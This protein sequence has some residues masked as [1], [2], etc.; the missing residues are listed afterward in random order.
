[1]VCH[2]CEEWQACEVHPVLACCPDYS[3]QF[4]LHHAVSRFGVCHE[5][6]A[7]LDQLPLALWRL[8]SQHVAEPLRAG[9]V[10]FE[11]CWSCWIKGG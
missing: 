2:Q 6:G 11:S 9:C 10:G 8:L 5:P 7:G 3:E 1:M 4:Q